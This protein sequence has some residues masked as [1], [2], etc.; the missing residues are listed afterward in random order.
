[1]VFHQ[2]GDYGVKQTQVTPEAAEILQNIDKFVR[3]WKSVIF[4]NKACID[5]ICYPGSKKVKG[6][7][8]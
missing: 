4:N 1:M 7:Y 8:S 2:K 5:S 3:T 6:A